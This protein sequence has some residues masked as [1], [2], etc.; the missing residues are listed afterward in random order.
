MYK[1]DECMCEVN[2][3]DEG[4]GNRMGKEAA[5]NDKRIIGGRRDWDK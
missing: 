3:I 5:R 4:G 1:R 2:G